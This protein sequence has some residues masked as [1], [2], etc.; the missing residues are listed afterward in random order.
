MRSERIAVVLRGSSDSGLTYQT[1]TIHPEK[2]HDRE[3]R[4]S[5]VVFRPP[6]VEVGSRDKV[7]VELGR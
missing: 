7:Q 3:C 6:S 4:P 1:V 2:W 5:P